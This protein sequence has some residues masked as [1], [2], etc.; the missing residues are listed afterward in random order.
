MISFLV[1]LPCRNSYCNT[2]HSDYVLDLHSKNY[3]GFSYTLRKEPQ[4]HPLSMSLASC[5][6]NAAAGESGLGSVHVCSQNISKPIKLP[7]QPQ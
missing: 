3:V 7:H 6:N 5:A 2:I 1:F 4:S